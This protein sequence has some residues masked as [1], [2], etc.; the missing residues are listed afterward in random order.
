MRPAIKM[1]AVAA[2]PSGT[3]GFFENLL[4]F[5]S[6]RPYVTSNVGVRDSGRSG[7]MVSWRKMILERLL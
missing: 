6:E 2:A 4:S 3:S 7:A 5:A 1:A